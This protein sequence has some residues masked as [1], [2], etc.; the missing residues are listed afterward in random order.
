MKK[1][2]LLIALI[3]VAGCSTQ[4]PTIKSE[5]MTITKQQRDYERSDDFRERLGKKIFDYEYAKSTFSPKELSQSDTPR[6]LSALPTNI[7]SAAE[8][9]QLITAGI[10]S[11]AIYWKDLWW[12]RTY[13]FYF[14]SD[15]G[16]FS[17][18]VYTKM[19]KDAVIHD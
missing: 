9:N 10:Y 12:G 19:K 8:A 15:S 5:S 6:Q 11:Y 2:L 1:L 14:Y 16:S 13:W 3:I 17:Y 18:D 7:L 4:L